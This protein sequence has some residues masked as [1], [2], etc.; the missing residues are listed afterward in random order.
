[1]PSRLTM[2][3]LHR[4]LDQELQTFQYMPLLRPGRERRAHLGEYLDEHSN[5][6][7]LRRLELA[8]RFYLSGRLDHAANIV[9]LVAGADRRGADLLDGKWIDPIAGCLG[10]YLLLSQGRLKE[11]ERHAPWWSTSAPCR[12]AMFCRCCT[13]PGAAKRKRR[14]Q[15][16]GLHWKQACPFLGRGCSPLVG[17]ARISG[18]AS[19]GSVAR[20]H[21]PKSPKGKALARGGRRSFLRPGHRCRRR[22]G[23]R[24]RPS[25]MRYRCQKRRRLEG[26]RRHGRP[27]PN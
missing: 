17:S 22:V 3:L 8:Q 20:H 6:N 14:R 18:R 11:I 9:G 24:R 7:M 27:N 4:G 5:P 1:M 26:V 12:T 23:W 16:V 21:P 25:P 13:T 15:T 19:L 10:G 2:L